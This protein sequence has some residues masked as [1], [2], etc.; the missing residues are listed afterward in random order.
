MRYN[1]FEGKSSVM[2]PPEPAGTTQP[3]CH[4]L[5]RTTVNATPSAVCAV[6]PGLMLSGTT[7]TRETADAGTSTERRSAD[8]SLNRRGSGCRAAQLSGQRRRQLHTVD[9]ERG[10][11]ADHQLLLARGQRDGAR[12][13]GLG[14]D[15]LAVQQRRARSC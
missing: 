8:H 1:V 3:C 2:T 14:G 10:A 12:L 11:G 5:T 15:G 13:A 4:P 6:H 7:R 9:D